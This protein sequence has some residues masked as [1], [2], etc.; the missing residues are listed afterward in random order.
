[1]QPVT[2]SFTGRRMVSTKKALEWASGHVESIWVP[3]QVVGVVGVLHVSSILGCWAHYKLGSPLLYDCHKGEAD[4]SIYIHL[5][6]HVQTVQTYILVEWW[7]QLD[8]MGANVDGLVAGTP[9]NQEGFS[10]ESLESLDIFEEA[11][12]WKTAKNDWLWAEFCWTQLQK[13][14]GSELH[15]LYASFQSKPRFRCSETCHVSHSKSVTLWLCFF[16]QSTCVAWSCRQVTP[17][18]AAW[19]PSLLQVL[20]ADEHLPWPSSPAAL[21]LQCGWGAQMIF[22]EGHRLSMTAT[23]PMCERQC[24]DF[25]CMISEGSEEAAIHREFSDFWHMIPWVGQV[26]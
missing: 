15:L 7:I 14:S 17:W 22:T 12:S 3:E 9:W 2:F 4:H 19:K 8:W 18:N 26:K 21:W 24:R 20:F 16:H 25:T 11:I 1:M 23:C 13:Q 5:P 10:L 6:V